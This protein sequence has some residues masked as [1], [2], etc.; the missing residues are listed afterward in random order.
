MQYSIEFEY[1]WKEKKEMQLL[2]GKPVEG[3]FM[4]DG[5]TARPPGIVGSNGGPRCPGCGGGNN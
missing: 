4:L 3:E 5:P 1:Q 2:G